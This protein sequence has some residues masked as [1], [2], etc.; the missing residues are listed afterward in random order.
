MK[1]KCHF[2]VFSL[3]FQRCFIFHITLFLLPIWSL[4][5]CLSTLRSVYAFILARNIREIKN[6]WILR[7]R[8]PRWE[9]KWWRYMRDYAKR[10]LLSLLIPAFRGTTGVSTVGSLC[11]IQI[12]PAEYCPNWDLPRSFVD[13]EK[14]IAIQTRCR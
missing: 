8:L 10:G 11:T 7:A 5:F 13:W 2:H 12:Y 4:V 9:C 1:L 3:V 14:K 6:T